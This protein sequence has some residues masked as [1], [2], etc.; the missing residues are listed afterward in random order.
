MSFAAVTVELDPAHVS[1]NMMLYS[2]VRMMKPQANTD[3]LDART[4][5]ERRRSEPQM[6]R[7]YPCL[8]L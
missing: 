4:S 5:L 6:R 3:R 8:Q 1:A 2:D 7:A